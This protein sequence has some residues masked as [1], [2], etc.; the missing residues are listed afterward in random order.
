MSN[1]VCSCS[2]P[3]HLLHYFYFDNFSIYGCEIFQDTCGLYIHIT[4]TYLNVPNKTFKEELAQS[5]ITI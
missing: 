3:H 4:K 5:P 1:F 2:T